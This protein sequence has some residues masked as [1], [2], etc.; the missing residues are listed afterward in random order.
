[1]KEYLFIGGPWSGERHYAD[2]SH[3]VYVPV[4]E[5]DLEDLLQASIDV[6]EKKLTP[7]PDLTYRVAVYELQELP[8]RGIHDDVV[9]SFYRVAYVLTAW[10]EE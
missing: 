1:M 3:K 5:Q 4:L 10:E 6:I 2:G 7:L 8:R 9:V